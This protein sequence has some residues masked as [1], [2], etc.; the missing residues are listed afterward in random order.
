MGSDLETRNYTYGVD[1]SD[2]N[3]DYNDNRKTTSSMFDYP[4]R[5]TSYGAGSDRISE[6]R[7]ID[8]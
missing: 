6:N 5:L 7:I 4:V 3:T 2:A 8:F 1:S